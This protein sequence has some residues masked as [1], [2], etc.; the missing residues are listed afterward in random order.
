MKEEE[1]D[2]VMAVNLKGAFNCTRAAIRHM[3][4]KGG[5][6][7]NI[8]SVAGIMGNAGQSNYAA[9]K[10]GLIGF[11]KSIAR[12]Y[13]ERNIRANVVAP[14]LIKTRMTDEID[15]RSKEVIIKSIPLKRYGE[16][17]DVAS[18]V[19]FLLS[20]YGAYITGEVINVNGGLYM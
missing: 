6:I 2:N 19:Y 20:E 16:P 12:E 8:S 9:S 1:W 10:A 18:A 3:L 13:G 5:G 7:V 17:Q 11:T 4:K 14:G 15:E